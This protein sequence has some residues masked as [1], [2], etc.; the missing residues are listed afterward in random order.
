MT[1]DLT[2]DWR[3]DSLA[4]DIELF[5]EW[6]AQHSETEHS[7]DGTIS[8]RHVRFVGEYRGESLR[9]HAQGPEWCWA[10]LIELF[11]RDELPRTVAA[12]LPISKPKTGGP[13]SRWVRRQTVL[14]DDYRLRL[15]GR[16]VAGE[17]A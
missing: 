4:E 1:A 10:E 8:W 5:H 2:D 15:A 7:S 6:V 14:W 11:R 3:E 16:R 12:I 13:R 17:R 9:L